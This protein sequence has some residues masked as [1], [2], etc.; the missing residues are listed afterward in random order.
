MS[1]RR[2]TE[3]SALS[4]VATIARKEVVDTFRDRR[5]IMVTLITAIV[6]GPL[7][8]MLVMNLV[9]RQGDRSREL[10]LPVSGREHAPALIA[11]LERQQVKIVAAPDDAEAK[12]RSGDLDVALEVDPKFEDDV[13]KGKPGTVH[14][15]FDRSRDRARGAIDHAESLLRAYNREWGR[16]RLLLRGVAPEVGNPL[17]VEARDLATPQSSGSLVLFLVAYYGLFAALMGGLA[18]ALDTTAGERER[19]SLEPLLATPAAP[20]E[21]AV[22]KWIGV[23]ALDAAVVA[24]T[25]SGFYLTLR[26][27]P[28]PSVGVPFL[29][30][31]RELARFI[32]VLVPLVALLPAV[33]IY[34]GA[35]GRTFKEAQANL[36]VLLFLVSTLPLLQLM[37]QR[38]EPWWLTAVPISG[39][40]TLLNRALRGEAL[41]SVDLLQSYAAPV[42]LAVAALVATSRLLS[43]E[44]ILAGR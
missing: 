8:L 28:L 43:R 2:E 38:K 17:N 35:R 14:L 10:T 30:G 7:F 19:M 25:L 24:L 22:G 23:V 15:V 3:G 20:I 32:V 36:S 29:F 39:Q 6:A 18:A 41:P 9:A 5:T 1:S 13:A 11:F 31:A 40:Y 37:M 34:V 27:A 4:R 26:F 42:L 33:L 44:S 21:L 16:G 12:I